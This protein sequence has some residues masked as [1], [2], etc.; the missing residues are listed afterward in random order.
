MQKENTLN[1][2]T[3]SDNVFSGVS[4]RRCNV[5]LGSARIEQTE[6]PCDSTASLLGGYAR[7]FRILGQRDVTDAYDDN[8]PLILTTG[9]LTGTNTEHSDGGDASYLVRPP[10]GR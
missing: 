3:P 2:N 4:I 6:I 7:S 9:I 5:D 8:N 10:S 1:G